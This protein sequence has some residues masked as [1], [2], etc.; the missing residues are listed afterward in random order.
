VTIVDENAYRDARGLAVP[1]PCVFEKAIAAGCACCAT[2]IRRALAEREAIG[3]ASPT[4]HTNCATLAALL[5]ERSTFALRLPPGGPL[6]HAATLRLACGGLAGV[7]LCTAPGE[8]DVH[9]LVAAAQARFGSLA[10]LPWPRVVEAVVAW[11]GRR[12]GEARR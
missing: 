11:Q 5:R 1:Q 10:D 3:C 6:P 4:A 2:S 12:R 9:R 8:T 7:R